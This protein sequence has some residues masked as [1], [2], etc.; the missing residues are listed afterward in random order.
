MVELW[1]LL[2]RTACFMQS[3]S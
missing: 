1:I 3:P 2:F